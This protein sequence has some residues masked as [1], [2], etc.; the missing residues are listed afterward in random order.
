MAL[1]QVR[2]FPDDVYEE[3]NMLARKEQRS[4]AQQTIVLIRS[5]LGKQDQ[6]KTLRQELLTGLLEE[7]P[8]ISGDFPSPADLIR[9][10]RER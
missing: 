2:S 8:A 1:L 4:V 7:P 9:E 10:D 5:A 6:R 3:L